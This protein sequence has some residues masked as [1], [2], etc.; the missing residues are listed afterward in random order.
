MIKI[1]RLLR[2]KTYSTCEIEIKTKQLCLI[3][4]YCGRSYL[5]LISITKRGFKLSSS[6]IIMHK[7]LKITFLKMQHKVILRPYFTNTQIK[8]IFKQC[9]KL[10]H[11][12]RTL[13]FVTRQNTLST[14]IKNDHYRFILQLMISIKVLTRCLI[15]LAVIK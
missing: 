2:N 7:T 4:I 9:K 11:T 10:H 13:L 6:F 14:G 1:L 12:T 15:Y 5:S 3:Y 8:S